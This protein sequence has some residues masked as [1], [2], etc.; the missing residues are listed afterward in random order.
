MKTHN[1]CF[2]GQTGFGKSSLV[3]ALFGTHF[4]TDPLVSCTKEL[5]TVTTIHHSSKGDKLV[6]IYDTPGIGEFSSNSLYQ[7]YYNL[8]VSKADHI[9]LVV[10]LDR[11]DAT[12]QDLL[13]S[14]LPYVK[15]KKVKFTIAIN[16]IDSKG[17]ASVDDY[18]QWDDETNSPTASCL[19]HIAERRETLMVNFMKDFCFLPFEIV[20]VSA[21]KHY[22]LEGLKQRILK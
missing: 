15:N 17:V 3:N 4:N 5:Y 20:P 7:I 21:M 18:S 6:S 22:G 8:A 19:K 11:T 14:V 10:T 1:I 12:S 9:V 13:E 2:I 16:R